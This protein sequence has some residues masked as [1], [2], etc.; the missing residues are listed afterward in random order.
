M[1][2]KNLILAVFGLIFLV[3]LGWWGWLQTRTDHETIYNFLFNIVYG[4]PLLVIPL[5]PLYRLLK[6]RGSREPLHSVVRWGSLGIL[7]FGIAQTIWTYYNLWGGFE[8]P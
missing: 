8:V 1:Q 7:S 5:I 6:N 2:R 3:Y 4:L